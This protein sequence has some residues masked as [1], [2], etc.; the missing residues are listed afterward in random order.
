MSGFEVVGVILGVLPLAI[1]GLEHYAE[2]V[3]TIKRTYHYSRDFSIVARKLKTQQDIFRNTVSKFLSE[4][5]DFETQQKLMVNIGGRE[6][7]SPECEA[8]LRR[9][10]YDSYDSSLG[11]VCDISRTLQELVKKLKINPD[12]SVSAHDVDLWYCITNSMAT[13]T[14]KI[15]LD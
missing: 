11:C 9:R 1:S 8:A 7:E 2:G 5:V 10:L 4:C 13:F 6:W 3:R 15:R 12:G 14:P